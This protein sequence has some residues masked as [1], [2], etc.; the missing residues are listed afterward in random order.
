MYLRL[1][2]L[3]RIYQIPEKVR[4]LE[5]KLLN[6]SY[7]EHY[8]GLGKIFLT[9]FIFAHFLSILLILMTFLDMKNNWL[10]SVNAIGAPWY[11]QYSWA[12]YWGTTIMLT[13]G[14]GDISAA[15][16][17]EA[18]CLTFIETLGCITLAY[19]INCV[20]TLIANIRAE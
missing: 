13:V 20:G 15:N 16:Y 5:T 11:E 9:N 18:I 3:L 4:Y 14:F 7:K 2:F 8:W 1:V 10:S 12:Y 6:T 17:K 19:N